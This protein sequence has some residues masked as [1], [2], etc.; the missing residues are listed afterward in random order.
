MARV[1]ITKALLNEIHKKFKKQ[2]I[3]VLKHLNSLKQNPKKGKVLGNIENIV[4]KEIKYK[5]FR[6]YFITD[7]Y[8]IKFLKN[9]ELNDLI[10]K[11][12]K[13]SD[14]KTQQKTIN[15]IKFILRKFGEQG[16]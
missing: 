13:M 2:S 4:I 8:K 5:S 3:E 11:F 15:E 16:F 12:I 1:I 9:Q 10:I 6:F 14:K 7:N